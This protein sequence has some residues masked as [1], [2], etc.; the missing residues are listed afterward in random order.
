MRV[1]HLNCGTLRPIVGR[2]VCHV[3]ACEGPDGLVL[4]D[5]GFGLQDAADPARRVG[6]ARHLI[7]PVLDPSETAV[8]QLE[9]LGYVASD[10]RHVILTHCDLDHVGGLADFPDAAVHVF[11]PEWEAARFPTMRERSRYRG[12]L[13]A[14][15][16]KV[17]TYAADGEPWRGMPAARP[18]DGV[19]D[20]FVL[21][22]MVGHTRGHAIVAVDAGER[23]WLLHAGDAFFDRYSVSRPGDPADD[24]RPNR[25]L[26]AFEATVARWP[27]RVRENHR[28]LAAMRDDLT[29]FNAHDPVMFE[30]LA[31]PTA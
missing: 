26:L 19:G 15:G 24:R 10:V 4:V 11:G 22:P 17:V 7:R 13:W 1:H 31:A 23:G 29:L 2:L 27:R 5:T 25:G 12:V 28:A 6:V 14:H 21:V 3:L 18:L 16:P 9:M 30:R 8:R 20:G